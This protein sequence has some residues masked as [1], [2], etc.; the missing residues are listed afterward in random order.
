MND[1]P[2]CIADESIH[3][4][5]AELQYNKGLVK[6]VVE[7]TDAKTAVIDPLGVGLELGPSFYNKLIRNLGVNLSNCF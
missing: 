7:G 6:A 1:D 2:Q 4:V 3:C 5:L